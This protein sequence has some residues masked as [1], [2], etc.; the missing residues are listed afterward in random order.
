MDLNLNA[1]ALLFPTIS[2]LMLAYTNR[3]LAVATL[4]R[5]LHKEHN[6][7]PDPKL[8]AQ[9]KNLHLRLTLI[10][11]MQLIGGVCI[12][13][14]VVCMFFIFGNRI[15]WAT[16]LFGASLVLLMVS[17]VLSIVEIFF[18]T[19]ALKIELSDL[20]QEIHPELKLPFFPAKKNQ[21]KAN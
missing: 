12:L 3:F 9:I 16:Y 10:Q 17:I 2:L 6:R 18:S 15:L 21:D 4:V 1:P 13:L 20:E 8:V 5:Q 19:K 14:A 7:K 11:N